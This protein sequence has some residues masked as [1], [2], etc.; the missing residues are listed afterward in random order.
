M[1]AHYLPSYDWCCVKRGGS[2]PFDFSPNPLQKKC[3][4]LHRTDPHAPLSTAVH[5]IDSY[6]TILHHTDPHALHN[7]AVHHTDPHCTTQYRSAPY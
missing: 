3:T 5:H 4:T 6:F 1:A 2:L 7:H